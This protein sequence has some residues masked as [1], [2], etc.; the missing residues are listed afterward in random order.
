MGSAIKPT[1]IP[2][3]LS[4]LSPSLHGCRPRRGRT[5]DGPGR[6]HAHHRRPAN[7]RDASRPP[8]S[9]RSHRALSSPRPRRPDRRQQPGP[10]WTSSSRDAAQATPGPTTAPA[11]TALIDLA[12]ATTVA[13]IAASSSSLSGPAATRG[14]PTA[15]PT[16]EGPAASASQELQPCRS[17]LLLLIRS[18]VISTR[19]TLLLAAR[20]EDRDTAPPIRPLVPPRPRLASDR[21]AAG[22]AGLIFAV[23]MTAAM[24][25]IRSRSARGPGRTSG[26]GGRTCPRATCWRCTCSLSPGSRSSG[27]FAGSAC[28]SAGV[29]DQ[30][31]ATVF[32][33]S[34]AALHHDVVRGRGECERGSGRRVIDD[35][36]G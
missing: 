21:A 28:G 11:A 19:R 26:S 30:F 20:Q 25:L 9:R 17:R 5:V 14:L 15:E 33:G 31:F 27:S 10:R 32:I 24:L 6:G 1:D 12:G 22:V 34:G 3:S 2:T 16:S 7:R 4:A 8:E 29:E 13:P 23:P 35:N 18:A 36:E